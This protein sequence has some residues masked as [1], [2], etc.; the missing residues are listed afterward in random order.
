VCATALTEG[1]AKGK[2]YGL[3]VCIIALTENGAKET[4]WKEL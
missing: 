2:F 4:L 1:G 3:T